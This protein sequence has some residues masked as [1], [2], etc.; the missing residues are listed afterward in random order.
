MLLPNSFFVNN[1]LFKKQDFIYF[2]F[3]NISWNWIIVNVIYE[4][5]IYITTYSFQ[6]AYKAFSRYFYNC[7]CHDL[8]LHCNVK[9]PLYMHDDH[10]N[11]F[12]FVHFSKFP[13]RFIVST[14]WAGHIN[15]R[16]LLQTDELMFCVCVL[17]VAF[18]NFRLKSTPT[19]HTFFLKT[20]IT[21]THHVIVMI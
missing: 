20:E 1:I 19:G 18:S 13:I 11:Q 10:E 3:I 4:I 8:L 2:S 21:I 7:I 12:N 14:K 6:T 16:M 17:M 5:T 15:K 9:I